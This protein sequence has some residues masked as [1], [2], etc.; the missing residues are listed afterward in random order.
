MQILTMPGPGALRWPAAPWYPVP[1]LPRGQV[2]QWR[3]QVL[4]CGTRGLMG[5]ITLATPSLFPPDCH[6][7]PTAT[8]PLLPPHLH[9]PHCHPDPLLPCPCFHPIP[10]T[11]ASLFPPYCHLVA[12]PSLFPSLLPPCPCCH[13]VLI[14]TL[15]PPNP[16]CHHPHHHSILISTPFLSWPHRCPFVPG[17]SRRPIPVAGSGATRCCRSVSH[18]PVA[19][20]V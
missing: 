9:C 7:I 19:S 20:R 12:A 5:S 3:G 18:H 15:L 6:P 8:S 13:P 10:V 17:A 1:R 11:T 14:S 16:Q 4:V 2:A